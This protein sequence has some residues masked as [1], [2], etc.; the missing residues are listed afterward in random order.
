MNLQIKIS[1][2]L[3]KYLVENNLSSFVIGISGGID[4]AVTSALCAYTN[5]KTIVLT[6]PI[7]QNPEETDRGKNHIEWLKNRYE[8]VEDL[9]IDLTDTY[10]K[11]K[12]T[13][14]LEFQSDLSLANTRARI[15]MSTLYLIAG[16]SNGLVVGTG[17]KIEDF[18][19]GFFTKY[20]DGGVDVSPIADLMKSEVYKLGEEIGIIKE[21]MNAQPT[22]GLWNDGRTDED[23]LGVSYDDLEWAMDYEKQKNDSDKWIAD[24]GLSELQMNIINV[25]RRHRTTNIHKMKKIPVF[26]K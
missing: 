10:E 22:D 14:P 3:E 7:H 24:D 11:L 1:N 17:N 20:G 9:H 4:S 5:K 13:V 6:M 23:Q 26:K 2:W 18:G 8:K 15:R 12:A 21:I 19:V 25:Y 16:S